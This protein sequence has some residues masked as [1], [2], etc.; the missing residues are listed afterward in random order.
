LGDAVRVSQQ[1]DIRPSDWNVESI[2]YRRQGAEELMIARGTMCFAVGARPCSVAASRTASPCYV[3]AAGHTRLGQWNELD[4]LAMQGKCRESF[5]IDFAAD[6]LARVA[7]RKLAL[8]TTLA[9]IDIEDASHLTSRELEIE[10]RL[11]QIKCGQV[12]VQFDYFARQGEHRISFARGRQVMSTKRV[13]EG[14][15]V[16]T[17]LPQD[18]LLALKPYAASTEMVKAIEDILEFERAV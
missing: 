10:M 12:T 16:P 14:S 4:L 8:Q 5:L 7:D 11:M 6:S 15:L 1:I 13:A 17:P 9:S 2:I 18:M 3:Y